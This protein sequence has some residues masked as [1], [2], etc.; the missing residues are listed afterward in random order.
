VGDYSIVEEGNASAPAPT[1][2]D[3]QNPIAPFAIELRS[4]TTSTRKDLYYTAAEVA[5]GIGEEDK[6]DTVGTLL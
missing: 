4:Q 6:S 3:F 2:L 1:N 5:K